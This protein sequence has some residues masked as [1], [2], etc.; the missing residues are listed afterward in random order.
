M[1]SRNVSVSCH[2]MRLEALSKSKHDI[3][4]NPKLPAVSVLLQDLA[5]NTV[6]VAKVFFPTGHS[7]LLTALVSM[8]TCD[9]LRVT[10]S[11]FFPASEVWAQ[12]SATTLQEC[13]ERAVSCFTMPLQVKGVVKVDV[14]HWDISL[15]DKNFICLMHGQLNFW[16]IWRFLEPKSTKSVKSY[17]PHPA[18]TAISDS[19]EKSFS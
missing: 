1:I 17:S 3:H 10:H 15:W 6:A 9:M 5:W 8:G 13:I 18:T 11:H 14:N 16:V 2:L 19:F 12:L 7:L 4:G